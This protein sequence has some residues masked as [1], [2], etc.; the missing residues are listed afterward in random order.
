VDENIRFEQTNSNPKKFIEVYNSIERML[1]YTAQRKY[2][3]AK[4]VCNE[5]LKKWP[6]MKQPY[7]HLGKIAIS[8]HDKQAI[9]ANFSAYLADEGST[10]KSSD[11]LHVK[12]G[13]A[14]A[15]LNLGVIL[16]REG[17]LNQAMEHYEKALFYNPYSVKANYNLGSIYFRQNKPADAATY[18]SKA[19]DLDPEMSQANHMMGKI[20]FTQG[21]FDKAIMH[22]KKV[23]EITPD[24]QDAQ[25][26]LRTA[27]YK[28]ENTILRQLKSLR[29]NP[30]QP[31]LHNNLGTLFHSQGDFEKTVYHW[32]KA[33]QLKPDWTEILNSLSWLR[34]TCQDE[35]ISDPDEAVRLAHLA[36]ELTSYKRADFLD[37]LSVAYAAA[38]RF[39]EAVDTAEKA[40]ELALSSENDNLAGEIRKHLTFYKDGKA[41]VE[42]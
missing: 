20:R 2:D 31:K 34:A 13:Y 22:F 42:P 37:T 5:M 29:E 30:N 40:L 12:P 23:L 32:D 6:D 36:C 26:A 9:V 25:S 27:K 21:R 4:K 16:A 39:A 10:W 35:K 24:S 11:T 33:L 17:K 15:H 28:L 8:E 41:Y 18:Y 7:L 1:L 3:K 38:G 19:L 14:I